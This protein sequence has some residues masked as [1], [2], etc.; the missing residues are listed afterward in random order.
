V[1]DGFT[2]CALVKLH[3]QG[4]TI[5]VLMITALEDNTSVERAFAAGANDYIPKPI[6]FAVLSHRVCS[7]VDANMAVRHIRNLAYTDGL[8]GLPNRAQFLEQLSGRINQ[9]SRCG[10]SVTILFLDLDRFKYVNDTLGHHIGDR[11]LIAAGNR[12][13]SAVRRA[14]CVARLGG[15]EFIVAL[16]DVTAAE[17]AVAARN[18][19]RTLS[20]PLQIDGNDLFISASIGAAVFPRDSTDVSTLLK[21]ADLAMYK[22]KRSNTGVEFFDA[23][24]E[25]SL[26]GRV[27]L[28]SELRRAIERSELEVFYQPKA[29]VDGTTIVGVEALVRWRHP[30]RGLV[31]PNDFIPL[32]EETGLILPLGD[33]VLRTACSQVQAWTRQGM[34]ALPVAVNI[35][36]RQL[37]QPDFVDRVE[38][39]LRDTGLP[40]HLLEL[41]IT[42]STLM[43]DA[44]ATLVLLH[45]LRALG[46]RLSIDDFGTGYS[47]LVYLKR[48]PMDTL[49]IDGAF[50]RDLPGDAD[51]VV[52][53]SAII[54][55]A[56]SLRLD[57][58]AEGVETREQRAFL[59]QRS[60]DLIQGYL[61]SKPLPA[62]E[63]EQRFLIQSPSTAVVDDGYLA[64][65][66]D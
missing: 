52:I 41:E 63:F 58:V 44:E 25:R 60:C 54:A 15:D 18:I 42:E 6:C 10:G 34:K 61:L 49:K 45:R 3:P 39:A 62:N 9:A 29:L 27:R 26:S 35:S 5:P 50:I 1:M 46:V 36:G 2:A 7:I 57:V 8:T 48:F 23:S 19:C 38:R 11:L 14:D 16:T 43:E 30:T 22:A 33:L 24:M 21:H 28:E 20:D 51:D 32:A 65:T 13:R 12:I 56:H 4:A 66:Q 17:A 53:V 37:Q 47:S 55:L 59:E 40:P 64:S 31:P